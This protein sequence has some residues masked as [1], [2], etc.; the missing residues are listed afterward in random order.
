MTKHTDQDSEQT[1]KSSGQKLAKIETAKVPATEVQ[2]HYSQA[3]ANSSDD[4]GIATNDGRYIK[5]GLLFLLLTL[6]TFTIWATTAPLNS[7]LIAP[8]EVVVDSYRKTIQ[9]YEGGIIEQIYVRN[10]DNVQAGDPLIKLENT[11]FQAQ[12]ENSYKQMQITKAE[13][14]RLS[15]EQNLSDNLTFSDELQAAAREDRDVANAL[16]Q[17]NDL[18]RARISAYRQEADALETR[19]EQ[20]DA[21]IEGIDAQIIG[22]GKQLALLKEEEQAYTTLYNEGLGDNNRAR[23]LNRNIISTENEINKLKSER[24]RLKIQNTETQFQIATREQDFLKD[25]GDRLKQTQATYF[26]IL[27]KYQV[28]QDRVERSIVRAPEDGTIVDM[29]V[30]TLGSVAS[31]GEPL[32]DLVPIEDSF[33]VES[34]IMTNDINDI[35]VGQMADIRFSA[36][37]SR[38]TKVIQGEV[39]NVSADRLV[40]Q[41]ENQA[42]Y[43]L[44]RL[45]VTEQGRSDMTEDMA[46][47]PG[48]PAEVMIRR[49][50]RTFMSYLV[51]PLQD[52]FARSLTEK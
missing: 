3:T 33:V 10:G 24:A 52:S 50:E 22:L 30:H 4:L 19:L 48:M 23:E 9:H 20:T 25:V 45:K 36:F 16:K 17:Q 37:N 8:G 5:F 38:T 44:A 2:G 32:M 39:V 18:L 42:P 34:R 15:V 51:K 21:Q 40:P 49:G 13:L 31:A 26:D 46:L 47:I 29:K 14:E 28:A 1:P 27:E 43:Y 35:H 41:G 6:G 7:A 11:Q 12:L